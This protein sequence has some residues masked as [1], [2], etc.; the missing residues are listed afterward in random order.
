MRTMH[1]FHILLRAHPQMYF[2]LNTRFFPLF[3]EPPPPLLL[4]RLSKNS[5][6]FSNTQYE[7]ISTLFYLYGP[8]YSHL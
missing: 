3:S 1:T 6:T 8:L 2:V 4:T 5:P 7:N